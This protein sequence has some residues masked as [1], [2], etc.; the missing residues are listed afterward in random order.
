[1]MMQTLAVFGLFAG[2][3]VVVFITGLLWSRV[4]DED[5]HVGTNATRCRK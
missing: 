4:R 1:M 3:A 2:V 5:D